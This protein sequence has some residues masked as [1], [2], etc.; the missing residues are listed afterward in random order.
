[1]ANPRVIKRNLGEQLARYTHVH[2]SKRMWASCEKMITQNSHSQ[3]NHFPNLMPSKHISYH[4]FVRVKILEGP[5]R[6][7]FQTRHAKQ[8]NTKI[9]GF[10][11]Y[12]SL[13]ILHCALKIGKDCTKTIA[14]SKNLETQLFTY[15]IKSKSLSK[16]KQRLCIQLIP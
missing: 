4:I 15:F 9:K 8:I 12:I 1:M 2:T 7:L 13:C 10:T 16:H 14:R 5:V 11:L 6:F 3:Q